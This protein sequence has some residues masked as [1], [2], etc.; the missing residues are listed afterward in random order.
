ML[1]EL[2]LCPLTFEGGAVGSE[3]KSDE[4]G[5]KKWVCGSL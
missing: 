2:V 3:R 1:V 5:L 4:I